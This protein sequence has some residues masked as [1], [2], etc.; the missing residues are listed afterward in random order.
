MGGNKR[1]LL[2]LRRSDSMRV[3]DDRIREFVE[4]DYQRVVR[5]VDGMLGDI[6]ASED[7][8]CDALERAWTRLGRGDSIDNLAAW[9]TTVALNRARSRV[10]RT[11]VERR[12]LA[13]VGTADS[14]HVSGPDVA[15][16]LAVR[17]AIAA[18]PRRQRE[19]TVLRYF[20]GFSVEEAAGMLE[21]SA[22]SARSLL[23]EARRA[24]AVALGE[25]VDSLE[26][27]VSP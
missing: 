19:L 12:V 11:R 26:S 27:E 22:G 8:V 14:A 13:R 7:V 15:S 23:F 21:M 6:A 24:L 9:C 20:G 10:R 1:F 4:T 18:L 2:L 5:V 25:L 16:D 17:A 3:V